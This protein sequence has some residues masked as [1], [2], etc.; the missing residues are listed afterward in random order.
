MVGHGDGHSGSNTARQFEHVELLEDGAGDAGA[1]VGGY[2][3]VAGVIFAAGV[4]LFR[5]LVLR[6]AV[7]SGLVA[8]PAVW[9][10]SEYVRNWTTPHGSAG[11]LAY[12][13]LRFLPFLQ[14]A[15]I[16]GPWG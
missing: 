1:C 2:L 12:S 16:T 13:Q 11:S 5:V 6:G 10:T 8:L 7:W 3:L 9:V 14:L 15:S 4:L